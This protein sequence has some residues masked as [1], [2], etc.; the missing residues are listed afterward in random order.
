VQATIRF[1][2]SAVRLDV[3]DN[4]K[5]MPETSSHSA[6]RHARLGIL[7]MQERAAIFGGRVTITSRRLKGTIV[8]V[9]IPFAVTHRLPAASSHTDRR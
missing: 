8:R 4:G 3:R 2:K 6:P 7:G 9:R 1:G 5:G